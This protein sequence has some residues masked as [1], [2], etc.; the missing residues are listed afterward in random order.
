M[1][2]TCITLAA[3]AVMSLA[4]CAPAA[5]RPASAQI[6]TPEQLLAAMHDRYAGKWYTTLSFTQKTT[7]HLPN[8]SVRVDTWREYG[9]M[10]GR[11]RIEMGDPAANNG[12]IYANDSV[13]AVRGGNVVARRAQ[14]NSLMVLGFDVYAQPV[15]KSA[16]IL[17]EEGFLPGTLRRDSWNGRPMYVVSS[18]ANGHREF[19]VD[20]ENLLYVRSIEPLP[21]PA[22]AP[23]R[24]M[25]VRFEDYKQ[26]GGGWVAERV[27]I[28][29]DG[30]T[31][32]LEEYTDVKVNQAL[33]PELWVPE[34]W[35]T[36]PKP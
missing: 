16:E 1:N 5:T 4:A 18:D 24:V 36:A 13:Y 29:M 26:H 12:A 15:A 3:A 11:L 9:A 22:G 10:P 35:A 19:W 8:D 20:A 32:Q 14:R 21:G 34:K 7:R 2:R 6:G 23:A 25:D 33:S 27:D 30:K 17:R 31:F 28:Q